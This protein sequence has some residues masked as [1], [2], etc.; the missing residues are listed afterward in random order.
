LGTRTRQDHPDNRRRDSDPPLGGEQAPR[1]TTVSLRAARLGHRA[2]IRGLAGA[3]V[4]NASRTSD[5]NGPEPGH[6]IEEARSENAEA[7]GALRRRANGTGALARTF[8]SLR[9]MP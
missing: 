6:L 9:G 5:Q 1:A 4:T 2:A 3:T 7:G 8:G